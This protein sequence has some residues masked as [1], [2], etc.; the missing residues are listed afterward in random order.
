MISIRKGS[1]DR[2]AIRCQTD[3]IIEQGRIS[4]NFPAVTMFAP[5]IVRDLW[6][7]F[8]HLVDEL[9]KHNRL[10]EVQLTDLLGKLPK[11]A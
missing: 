7:G 5:A 11:S 3:K 8:D 10:D 1:N 4:V 6:Y 9:I 2:L